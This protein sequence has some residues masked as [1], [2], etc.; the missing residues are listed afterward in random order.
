[1]AY[2]PLFRSHTRRLLRRALRGFACA[3]LAALAVF[4]TSPSLGQ[5]AGKA[6]SVPGRLYVRFAADSQA[7][8]PGKTVSAAF[9]AAASAHGVTRLEKAFPFLDV[10]AERRALSPSAEALRHVYALTYTSGAEP[11]DAAQAFALDAGVV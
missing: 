8:A 3:L 6:E 10:L 7:P 11:A 1:M 9:G 5:S 2:S 4:W